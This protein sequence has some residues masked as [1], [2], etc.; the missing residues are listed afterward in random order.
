MAAAAAHCGPDFLKKKFL[1]DTFVAVGRPRLETFD[2]RRATYPNWA[3]TGMGTKVVPGCENVSGQ[4]E[5]NC[6]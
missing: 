1:N 5:Q 4:L 2:H 3:Y 6:L